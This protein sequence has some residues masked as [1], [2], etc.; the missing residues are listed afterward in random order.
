MSF[1]PARDRFR[2]FGRAKGR[3]LSPA[4]AALME[5]HWPRLEL[6]PGDALPPGPRWLE[7][8]YGM[9]SHLLHLARTH[10]DV[11]VIGAEPFLN[12]TAKVVTGVDH[13]K[14][15]NVRLFRGDVRELM[16]ALPEACLA[17]VLILF[18]D[19]WPKARHNKRRLI[20]T[21][22]VEE[23]SRVIEPGGRLLFASDIPH[24]VDWALSRFR[25]HARDTGHGFDWTGFDPE[26]PPE[27]WPGTKYEAKA[28]REG[29]TPYW[30]E[31]VRA[32]T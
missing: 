10:P 23:L 7:I 31:L 16:A 13:E 24:Y 17:R 21:A 28:R 20:R 29:R 30:F 14:L 3:T 19:P 1:D 32:D 27:G 12:G 26:R 8:G 5:A 25:A 2:T 6:R 18:P 15:N 11:S 9:G 22:F 4:Q